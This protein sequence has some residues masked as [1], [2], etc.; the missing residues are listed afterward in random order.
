MVRVILIVDAIVA[1]IELPLGAM[2]V[3]KLESIMQRFEIPSE[4]ATLEE[5][6]FLE[7]V[8]RDVWLTSTHLKYRLTVDCDPPVY[9]STRKIA[10]LLLKLYNK[11]VLYRRNTARGS[12]R[13]SYKVMN[14]SGV[15]WVPEDLIKTYI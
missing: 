14:H 8:A 7:L 1:L 2:S 10:S 9:A 6:V 11:G 4:G 12:E 5:L 3:E 15:L 13:Y